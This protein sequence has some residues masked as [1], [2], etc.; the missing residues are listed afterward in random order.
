MRINYGR[1]VFMNVKRVCTLFVVLALVVGVAF[2]QTVIPRVPTLKSGV[3]LKGNSSSSGYVVIANTIAGGGQQIIL[4]DG[5][6][7]IIDRG[8]IKFQG[9]NGVVNLD[10]SNTM[11]VSWV[12]STTFTSDGGK[13]TWKWVR[14]FQTKDLR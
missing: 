6:G 4:R 1:K 7:E 11:I 14:D 5:D 9:R 12:D 2:A 13:V 3:Y 10:E 8:V